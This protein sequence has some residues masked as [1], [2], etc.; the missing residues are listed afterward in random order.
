MCV[1]VLI[2]CNLE[3][4]K[5]GGLDTIRAVAPYENNVHVLVLPEHHQ[6]IY[7]YLN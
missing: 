2:L 3:I 5:R 7:K 1:C 4:S 6:V